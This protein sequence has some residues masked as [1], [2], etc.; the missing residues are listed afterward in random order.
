[1]GTESMDSP[2][3]IQQ[4]YDN[5]CLILKD[6][7]EGIGVFQRRFNPADAAGLDEILLPHRAALKDAVTQIWEMIVPDELEDAVAILDDSTSIVLDVLETIL[8][9]L[10]TNSRQ[11]ITQIGRSGRRICRV[12][13]QL[14][15][16]GS[17]SSHLNQLFLEPDAPYPEETPEGNT[18]GNVLVGLNHVALEEGDDYAR[19]GFSF[20]VPESYDEAAEWPLVIALHGGSGHGRDFIWTWLREA[21]SR[22]FILLSPTSVD[23]TW[24]L[25][26]PRVDG[27]RLLSFLGFMGERYNLDM[28]R[29]LLTGMSDGAT[30]ALIF[31]LQEQTPFTAFAPIA[32]VLPPYE[33][34]AA[35]GRRIYWTHGTLDWMFP[36]YRARDGSRALRKAGADIR[37]REIDDLSHTYPREENDGI[38]KWF[39]PGLALNS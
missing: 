23:R 16:I 6:A 39:D 3:Q 38:L 15:Q 17:T 14:Y 24:S 26:D 7:I 22:K 21:R 37:F 5:I 19:G 30:F 28:D 20:F 4:K 8:A 13:D 18:A 35:G 10:T 32:G 2:D 31:S 27:D 25:M 12:Q 11:R 36:I 1:M 34:Q 29:V 9:V 33:L